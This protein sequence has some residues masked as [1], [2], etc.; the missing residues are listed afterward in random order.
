[1]DEKKVE[2][3]ELYR[4]STVSAG[5]RKLWA[6]VALLGIMALYSLEI[7]TYLEHGTIGI[8]GF[9]LDT[10]LLALWVWRV[11]WT[12]ELILYPTRLV[13]L[14][15]GFGFVRHYEVDLSRAESY[16]DRYVKSFFRKTKIRHYIHRY[17]SLDPNPQRLLCFTEGKKNKL[18]GLIF[19]CSDDF[20]KEFK[21][22]LPGKF[23]QLTEGAPK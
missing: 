2:E 16:T 3:K 21:K 20:L 11:L 1:M 22:V 5:D 9:G 6:I 17:C 23:L 4:E 10:V 15:K 12:Y 18:A 14:S 13:V 8:M 7:R 19:K